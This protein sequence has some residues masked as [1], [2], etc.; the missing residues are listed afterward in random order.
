MIVSQYFDGLNV[1]EWKLKVMQQCQATRPHNKAAQQRTMLNFRTQQSRIS[2]LHVFITW[3]RVCYVNMN[4]LV[5]NG[6]ISYHAYTSVMLPHEP[7]SFFILLNYLRSANNN[8]KWY[9]EY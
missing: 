4:T 7:P 6:Y 9:I 1:E 3:T 8:S 5:L 2:E